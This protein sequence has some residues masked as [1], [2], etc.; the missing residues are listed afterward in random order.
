MTYVF[1]DDL[2]FDVTRIFPTVEAAMGEIRRRVALPY[3]HEDNEA[4]CVSPTCGCRRY[5]IY[6]C[7]ERDLPYAGYPGR[8]VHVCTISAEGVVWEDGFEA[9]LTNWEVDC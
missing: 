8:K 6:E 2:H 3:E 9:E 1:E 7:G 5:C 4:P